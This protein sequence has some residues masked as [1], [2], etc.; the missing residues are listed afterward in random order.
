M[1]N[2]DGWSKKKL[3]DEYHRLM[4]VR[5]EKPLHMVKIR[6]ILFLKAEVIKN[7]LKKM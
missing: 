1:T 2:Y 7:K 6:G 3:Q 5:S 4:K